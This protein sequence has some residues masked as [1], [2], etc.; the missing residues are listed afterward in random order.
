[1]YAFALHSRCTAEYIDLPSILVL[2]AW[3]GAPSSSPW[4]PA[5]GPLRPYLFESYSGGEL[6]LQGSMNAPG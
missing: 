2:V 5:S 6:G 3:L 4:L 1:M